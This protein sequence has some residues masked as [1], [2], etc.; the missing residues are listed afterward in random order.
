MRPI[1]RRPRCRS[2]F[3]EA[4][5]ESL[6]GQDGRVGTGSGCAGAHIGEVTF[7]FVPYSTRSLTAARWKQVLLGH[8]GRKPEGSLPRPP[9]R[10]DEVR[11]RSGV[12]LTSCHFRFVKALRPFPAAAVSV[13]ASSAAA[14]KWNA[15]FGT[16]SPPTDRLADPLARCEWF[17]HAG[18]RVC[19]RG[20]FGRQ[21]E[22]FHGRLAFGH[23]AVRGTYAAGQLMALRRCSKRG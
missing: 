12:G 14:M 22:H 2:R 1:Q 17:L 7:G 6:T 13:F 3:L 18:G 19:Q 5:L 23:A 4:R 15:C 8:V 20:L 9:G 16:P 11:C 10:A 21:P